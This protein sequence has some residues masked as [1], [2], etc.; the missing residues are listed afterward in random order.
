[1]STDGSSRDQAGGEAQYAKP[2]LAGSNIDGAADGPIDG[3]SST[4]GAAGYDGGGVGGVDDG[5]GVGG[6]DGPAPP[7]VVLAPV[8][9]P[10]ASP[11][12]P[13]AN[14]DAARDVSSLPDTATASPDVGPDL[15]DVPDVPLDARLTVKP[16][17]W[18]ALRPASLSLD[19]ARIPN[20][21]A[22]KSARTTRVLAQA[23]D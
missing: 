6:I 7:D 4:G 8:D 10:P 21:T 12:N 17:R 13:S 3:S 23:P 19:V 20:A 18:E 15:P 1:V 16:A 11:D 22:A 9:V 2:D 5:G 14:Q